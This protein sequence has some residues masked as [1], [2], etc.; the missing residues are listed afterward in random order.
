MYVKLTVRTY[1]E[2]MSLQNTMVTHIHT[3]PCKKNKLRTDMFKTMQ[4][5]GAIEKTQ[6]GCIREKNVCKL[7]LQGFDL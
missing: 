6:M 7:T 3:L 2:V 5:I 4:N 1:S